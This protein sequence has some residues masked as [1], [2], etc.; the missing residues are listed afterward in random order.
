VNAQNDPSPSSVSFG[1]NY[2]VRVPKTASV[3]PIPCDEWQKIRNRVARLTDFTWLFQSLGFALF[4]TAASTWV[5]A[6]V[7]GLDLVRFPNGMA[8]AWGIVAVSGVAGA[9]CV[10]VAYR[11]QRQKSERAADIVEDMEMLEK[12][13]DV[14]S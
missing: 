13:Y 6:K 2:E 3:Y 8:W 7:G 12:R 11:E 14:S 9:L 5:T 1:H 4:G 10:F